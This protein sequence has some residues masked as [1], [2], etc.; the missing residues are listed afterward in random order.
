M[1]KQ[2]LTIHN[3]TPLPEEYQ[4]FTFMSVD[5]TVRSWRGNVV[6]LAMLQESANM[7]SFLK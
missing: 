4:L 5:G 3:K 1:A 7:T 2:Q 6:V